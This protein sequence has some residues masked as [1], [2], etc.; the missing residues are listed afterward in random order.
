MEKALF[1]T[2]P[3]Q[4]VLADVEKAFLFNINFDMAYT[5]E[6]LKK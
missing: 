6:E 1:L 4:N 2:I 3:M 5:E